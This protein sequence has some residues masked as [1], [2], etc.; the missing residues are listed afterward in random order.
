MIPTA[1]EK[2]ERFS[3]RPG[4][5]GDVEQV[6]GSDEGG[7]EYEREMRVFARAGEAG[8]SSGALKRSLHHPAQAEGEERGVPQVS[9]AGPQK[10]DPL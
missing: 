7:G 3:A 8:G 10:G 1:I 9:D 6:L 5:A 4:D 2:V